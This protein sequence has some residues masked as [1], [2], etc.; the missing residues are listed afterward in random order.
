MNIDFQTLLINKPLFLECL[1]TDFESHSGEHGT[2]P[3]RSPPVG[4]TERNTLLLN[5]KISALINGDLASNR[6]LIIRRSLHFMQYSI[7]Y[8]S[9]QEVAGIIPDDSVGCQ[10]NGLD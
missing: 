8:C 10:S 2:L 4:G 6:G 7:T 5:L 9:L 3:T 1:Q